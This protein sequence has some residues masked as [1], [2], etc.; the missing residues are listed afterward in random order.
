MVALEPLARTDEPDRPEQ[1]VCRANR[2]MLVPLVYQEELDQLELPERLVCKAQLETQAAPA[3]QVPWEQPV[4]KEMT[5]S[6]VV[7]EALVQLATLVELD[8]LELP[9]KLVALELAVQLVQLV[10]LVR[11]ETTVRQVLLEPL[12]LRV[13]RENPVLAC[14][15]MRFSIV[16]LK[17][18]FEISIITV[19]VMTLLPC[20]DVQ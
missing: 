11:L 1:L 20:S 19:R 17:K 4:C 15:A 7:R 16:S 3:P 2:E 9:V 6:P 5:V 8:R 10:A 14:P 12:D 18:K 13:R